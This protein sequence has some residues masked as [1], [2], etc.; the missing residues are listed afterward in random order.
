MNTVSDGETAVFVVHGGT[1]M[2]IMEAYA[3]PHRDYFDYHIGTG[4][5]L[6]C[7]YQNGVIEF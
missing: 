3:V 4:Q 5:M 7:T 1:I 2:S 6:S